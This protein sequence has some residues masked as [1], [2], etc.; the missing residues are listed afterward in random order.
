M[1]NSQTMDVLSENEQI[2][3]AYR[4]T[5]LHRFFAKPVTGYLTITNKRAIYHSQGKAIGGENS[6]ISEMPLE[7]IA[8]ISTYSGSSFNLLL[9]AVFCGVLY[10]LTNYINYRAPVLLWVLGVLLCLPAAIGSLFKFKILN[11]SMT[12]SA[13]TWIQNLSIGEW[14]KSKPEGYFWNAANICLYIG[15]PML[16]IKLNVIPLLGVLI[17][18]IVYFFIFSNVFGKFKTFSLQIRSKTAKGSGIL[19]PGNFALA[20]LSGNT[21]AVKTMF[22]GPNEDAGLI[23]KEL[24]AIILDIQ[25]MGD[26]GIKKWKK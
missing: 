6:V 5:K 10:G 13:G 21:T 25:Q 8:G 23:V 12:D 11:Q 7:D 17:I 19:I 24:G 18:L 15:A 20:L 3:R 9:F 26:L 1:E 4:C 22:A 2:V 14:V 16:A